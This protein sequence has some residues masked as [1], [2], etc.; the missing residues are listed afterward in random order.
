MRSKMKRAIAEHEGPPK[1]PPGPREPLVREKLPCYPNE[2]RSRADNDRLKKV[3]A[4][5][6]QGHAEERAEEDPSGYH[7]YWPR[8]IS[9][10]NTRVGSHSST[11][12]HPN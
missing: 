6:E 12:G 5:G 3:L 2:S 10:E 11:H 7:P 1:R 9:P 8:Q 4:E